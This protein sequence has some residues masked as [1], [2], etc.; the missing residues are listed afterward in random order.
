MFSRIHGR[1]G[2]F[3][4][5]CAHGRGAEGRILPAWCIDGHSSGQAEPRGSPY[6]CADPSFQPPPQPT[7]EPTPSATPD[8][9][10][11]LATPT[12]TPTAQPAV[13]PTAQND[14]VGPPETIDIDGGGSGTP[15]WVWVIVG[16]V[17]VAGAG[18]ATAAY[19][20]LRGHRG[21]T[22]LVLLLITGSA[23]ALITTDQ[24]ALADGDGP[25]NRSVDFYPGLVDQE[26]RTR[27]GPILTTH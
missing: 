20:L 8:A 10:T 24:T 17:A 3:F 18:G 12:S 21:A 11:E 9:G 23:I 4:C 14:P 16:V 19:S 26:N 15:V 13:A 22:P 6:A 5:I 25:R 27:T 1:G 7:A 2:W